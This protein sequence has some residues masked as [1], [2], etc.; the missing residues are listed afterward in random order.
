VSNTVQ[1]GIDIGGTFT[2]LFAVDV[3][4]GQVR[5]A[6]S[7]TTPDDL[8]RGVFDCL[9]KAAIDVADVDTLVHG[10]TV[11][12]N[13]AIE[14]TGA[15]TA[16]VVTRGTRDVYAI[17]RGNRP[18]AY[19]P[20]FNRPVPLVPRRMTFEADERRTA[21]GDVLV[22][23]EP[24]HA[25]D[26]TQILAD[27]GAESV[28]VCFLHSYRNP[29]HEEEMGRV[30]RKA[31]P[32]AY[33]S[34]SH[35]I[36]REYRE[37][38]RIST[39]VLNSY[40]GPRSRGYIEQIDHALATREFGGR[41]LIMQSNGGV[42][43]PEMAKRN[44]V[45]MMESGPV[46]GVIAS[47]HVA[48]EAGY[49][50]VIT[51]D[52]GGTTAKSS[53]VRGG[54]PTIAH[55]Y[56]IG[57]YAS[58]HPAMLPVV[59]IVEVG[60]GGGSIAWLDEVGALAVGP[61]S[62]GAAPGPI[63]YQRGGTEPTVTDANLVLGR[64][65]AESFLGGEMP[66]DRESAC[67]GI[68]ERL[69]TLGLS[70]VGLAMG[71]IRL[72]VTNMVLA[73]RGVSVERGYDP[74]DFALFAQGGAGPMHALE[75]ARELGV[76][77]VIVPIL[78]AHF[79]AV[80]M[81]TADLRH[82]YVRTYY[83]ELGEARFD[84]MAVAFRDLTDEAEATLSNEGVESA[85]MSFQRSIDMRYVGQEFSLSIPF[86]EEEI[87][88]G[89]PVAVRQ[90]FGELHQHRYGH[91][92]DDE[93][94]EIVNLRVTGYGQRAKPTLT[95]LNAEGA[96]PRIGTRSV[97]FADPDQP[98]ACGVYA[99]DR[100]RVGSEVLGPAVIEEQASTTVLWPGDAATVGAYGEIVV[101]VAGR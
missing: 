73:V 12:I 85:A 5:Q 39:T 87:S 94:A 17:G 45:T 80:G 77:R 16:L 36:V 48:S 15:D 8:S 88:L 33:V 83:A 22:A 38:E 27:A 75:I 24:G 10:S 28:A 89:D 49:P 54:E 90:R 25:E 34:L 53:L 92:A 3:V 41:F 11:A 96:D 18:D 76:P 13:I 59:D 100:L 61:R 57:G 101:E 99:R 46:S 51:F 7:L 60:A 32:D 9:R 95:H 69:G 21:D 84:D 68:T 43:S 47:A 31:L 91:A 14:R 55:G 82:D 56:H 19:D 52:M 98:V 23:L 6:K 44:P 20:F 81:L 78:P 26:L 4:S 70:E 42:M 71:I 1:L 37:Y 58:G 97:W 66:L 64:I 2:D 30:L 29:A 72:A 62:A 74:R 79:S 63:C 67:G 50:D 65:G 86:T 40:V 93:E 35:E